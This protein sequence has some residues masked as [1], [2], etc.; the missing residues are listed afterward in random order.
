MATKIENAAQVEV[1]TIE[2]TPTVETKEEAQQPQ[3]PKIINL[4]GKTYE[5]KIK[6]LIANGWKKKSGIKVK[7]VTPTEKENHDR[8]TFT[9]REGFEVDAYVEDPTTHEFELKKSNF[10]YSSTYAI[11]GALK[12]TEDMGWLANIIV[13]DPDS[14][15]VLFNGGTID[16]ISLEVPA[17]T[18]YVNPFSSTPEIKIWNH[19]QIINIITNL[20]K[21]KSGERM[22]D[23]YYDVYANRWMK[24]K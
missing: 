2:T 17:G 16:I 11:A 4:K 6:I 9:V 13:E 15:N 14:L 22:E 24:T 5:E 23:K 3:E 7:N 19:N 12:E 18:P 10:I 21:G 20:K 1:E 8:I